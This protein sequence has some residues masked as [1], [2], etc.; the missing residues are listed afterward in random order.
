MKLR[1]LRSVCPLTHH[2]LWTLTWLSVVTGDTDIKTDHNC[3]RAS[4]P[5]I[6]LGNVQNAL[7]HTCIL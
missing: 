3:I 2:S 6:S 7:E 5:D 1:T 4:D